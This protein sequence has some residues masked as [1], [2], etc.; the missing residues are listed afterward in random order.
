[1]PDRHTDAS[2]PDA[3]PPGRTVLVTG[4]SGQLGAPLAAR[5]SASGWA[6]RGFD[7]D[8]GDDLRDE[9]AVAAAVEGCDAVVHAGALAHDTAGSPADIMATNLLG[10]WHVLIAAERSGV[11]RVVYLSSGQV[12]GFAEGEGTPAYL[13]VDDAHPLRAARPYGLSN[14]SPRR[15]VPPGRCAPGSPRWCCGP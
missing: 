10:T 5:L 13:P 2:P 9:A 11:S 4:S 14:G 6:V 7:L 12:F 8:D 15:C 1:M 3:R